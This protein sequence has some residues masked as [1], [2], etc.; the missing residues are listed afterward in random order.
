MAQQLREKPVFWG[1]IGVGLVSLAGGILMAAQ[2][3]REMHA[4][5]T[6]MPPEMS[7]MFIDVFSAQNI[8]FNERGTYSASD[9]EVGVDQ[10][11]CRQYECLLTLA[12]DGKDYTFKMTKGGHSFHI[13]AKSPIPVEDK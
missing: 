11:K 6:D 7:M 1:F 4:E 12:P 2:V 10:E 8:L 9:I 13:R 3:A 5:K